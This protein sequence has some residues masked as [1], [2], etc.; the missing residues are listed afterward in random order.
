MRSSVALVALRFAMIALFASF[1]WL[2]HAPSARAAEPTAPT[3]PAATAESLAPPPMPPARPALPTLEKAPDLNAFLGQRVAR[4][5]VELQGE[6]WGITTLPRPTTLKVG[7]LLS[8]LA[9]RNSIDELTRSGRF[10]SV[11]ATAQPNAGGVKVTLRVVA[12]RIIDSLRLE[13]GGAKV[14]RED[15]LREA[16][17]VEGGELVGAD[18]YDKQERLEILLARHGYPDAKVAIE[19]RSTDDPLRVVVVLDVTP[20]DPR[21]LEERAFYVSAGKAADLKSLTGSYRVKTQDRADETALEAADTELET[22]LRGRGYFGAE[23]NHD[24]V[25]YKGKVVLRVRVDPGARIVPKFEGNDSYDADALTEAL[26]LDKESDFNATRFADKLRDFYQKRGFYDAEVTVEERGGPKDPVHHQLF[27]IEEHRRVLVTGRSY[28]CLKVDEIRRLRK[29]TRILFLSPLLVDDTA[30]SPAAIG[31]EIDS[32]LEEELP[33]ADLVASPDPKLVDELLAPAQTSASHP[34]PI[35]LEPVSVYVPG[36]YERALEHVQQL[37]RNQGYLHAQVGPVQVIRRR[38]DPKSPPGRCIPVKPVRLPPDVCAYDTAGLP[39]PVPDLDPSLICSPDPQRGVRCEDRMA[40]RIPIKL[41]PRVQLYDLKIRG[42]RY[43]SEAKLAEEAGLNLGRAVSIKELDEGRRRVLDAL[44]EEGFAYADVKVSLDESPD[45]SRARALLEVQEGEQVIVREIVIQG[46]ELT[47]EG[48]IR[49]RIALQVG[50]PYRL[51]DIRKTQERIATLGVFASVNVSLSDPYV[52]QRLKTV[53]ITVTELDSHYVEVQPGFSTGEGI[54]FAGEY[55]ERNLFRSAIGFSSRLQLSYLPDPLIIDPEVRR[56]WREELGDGFDRMGIRVTAR[57]DFPEIGLGPLMRMSLDGIAQQQPRRD[58]RLSKVA[59]IPT[60]TYRPRREVILALSQTVEYNDALVFGQKSVNA[61]LSSGTVTPEVARLLRVPNGQSD[62]FAQRLVVTWDRRDDSFNPHHGTYFV[63]GLEHIDWF[64][65]NDP[66]QDRAQN[67]PV[68]GH[69]LRF[70][71]TFAGYVPVG[72]RMTLAA[73]IRLGWNYQLVGR[74]ENTYP[75]RLFFLGG[76]ESMRAWYQDTFIPQE[77]IDQILRDE[78][79][80]VRGQIPAEKA[81]TEKQIPVR[82]GNLMV[83][84]K[85]ELRIP[86]A[87]SL[88]TVAFADIGNLWRYPS[89]PFDSGRFPIRA[90]VGSGLR[91]QTPIGPAAL[92]FG[93]NTTRYVIRRD[94]PTETIGAVQFGIGIF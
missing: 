37:F 55:G 72:R 8:M 62:A 78:R 43:L 17:L 92:D 79:A 9:V 61:L 6:A 7:D 32:F 20:G 77:F 12:R 86:L 63:S 67:S 88:E 10:A 31:R 1:A 16:D 90:G 68:E 81:L 14:D 65:L 25:R 56:V 71:E 39:L 24:V 57:L 2:G 84:P 30:S 23:V 75:D 27:H 3:A 35:D 91:Y 29:Q 60:F 21:I 15:L 28:P 5:D 87:G 80:R 53:V 83:N 58:F 42:A 33:G 38:C 76:F 73:E 93:I 49:R 74:D 22:K 26:E 59:G 11:W 4:V 54:R 50:R 46:A 94:A 51:S 48:V 45:H 70:T 64:S 44:R 66:A 13:L 82:G 18:L 40:L 34:T 41:G 69:T 47:R 52:P 89:T 85:V 36:T 19:T